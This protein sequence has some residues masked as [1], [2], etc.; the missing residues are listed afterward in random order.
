MSTKFHIL[1]EFKSGP[2]GGGNQFL[3]ALRNALLEKNVYTDSAENA[4]VIL[5][6]SHHFGENLEQLKF[7]IELKQSKPNLRL[8]HRLDGPISLIRGGS[9]S[10][11]NLIFQ[12]N[13]KLADGTIFQTNWSKEQSER[14]GLNTRHLNQIITNAPDTTIFSPATK[15]KSPNPIIKLINTSWAM[16]KRKGLDILHHLDDVLDFSR[17]EM[18]FVGNTKSQFKNIRT[19]PP[20]DSKT[21]SRTLRA[22]DIFIAPSINDPCSNS[23][24][25]A[26]H[27]GLPALARNSGGHPELVRG[28]GIMFDDENDVIDKLEMLASSYND[29]RANITTLK[30][31]NIADQYLDFACKLAQQHQHL[32]DLNINSIRRQTKIYAFRNRLRDAFLKRFKLNIG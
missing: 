30:I 25:E 4:D 2:W 18:T 7:L 13:S 1:Y 28:G 9:R 6:N 5:F 3:K 27:S 10:I 12:I 11:D 24:C 20:Q 16:N 32:E 17:F 14:I 19:L 29:Y 22:H 8:M 31:E 26:L 21:L 15:K 23:L